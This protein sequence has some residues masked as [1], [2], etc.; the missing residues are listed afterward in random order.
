MC[1]SDLTGNLLALAATSRRAAAALTWEVLASSAPDRA[2][3]M[4]HVTPAN[5]WALDIAVAVRLEIHP[6]GFLAV[7]HLAVPAPYVPHATF[8]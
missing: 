7:R 3:E 2:V 5:A 4:G 6:R 8:L 1:S